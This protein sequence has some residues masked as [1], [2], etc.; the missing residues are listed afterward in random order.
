LR[1]GKELESPHMYVREDRTEVDSGSDVEK[2]NP[3][4]APS[5]RV[6]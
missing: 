1:S 3:M 4:E 5:E 6:I 2:D